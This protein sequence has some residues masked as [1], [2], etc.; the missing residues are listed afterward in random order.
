MTQLW[1]ANDSMTAGSQKTAND[2]AALWSKASEFDS[3]FK[4]I[5]TSQEQMSREIVNLWEKNKNIDKEF[6]NEWKQEQ[7]YNDEL[8]QLWQNYQM[9][10][11][12]M[13]YE[14]DYR[15]RRATS[16]GKGFAGSTDHSTVNR[17]MLD[18]VVKPSA[19]DVI[20]A[21]E[22]KI[23]L[24]LGCG[25]I[26]VEG[27]INVDARDL[28]GV[29]VVADIQRLPYEAESVDEIFSAHL[30]EHF[31]ISVME[32]E[33]MPY[34]TSLLREGGTMRVI[35]PDSE[36]MIEDYNKGEMTFDELAHVIM[37]GQDYDKD[38]HYTMYNARRVEDL[39]QKMGLKNIVVVERGR[40]NGGCRETEMTATK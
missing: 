2:I 9:L 34:W 29:D 21:N 25:H 4:N 19:Q 13:F 8:G 10:R 31:E 20:D 38:Y 5:W 39:L 40:K 36:S 23:R 28:P 35:F 12:E 7:R 27:Y 11:Q 1:K 6:Q 17:E 33:I 32:R 24:N 37:G 22:G 14:I 3:G 26:P 30:L 18:P 15:I 16:Q